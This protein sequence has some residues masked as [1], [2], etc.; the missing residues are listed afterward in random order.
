MKTLFLGF[1]F[2]LF[3]VQTQAQVPTKTKATPTERAERMTKR[4]T[5]KLGLSEEQVTAVDELNRGL[6]ENIGGIQ[7]LKDSDMEAFRTQRRAFM[8][9]HHNAILEVLDDEQDA[10]YKEYFQQ[11]RKMRQKRRAA[12]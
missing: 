4:M 10:K 9:E 12:R 5:E 6:A 8:K 11:R 3:A 1:I 2:F 7:A